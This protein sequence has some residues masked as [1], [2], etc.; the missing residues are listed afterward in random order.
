MSVTS[1]PEDLLPGGQ[2]RG[3]EAVQGGVVPSAQHRG[4]PDVNVS[5]PELCRRAVTLG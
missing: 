5:Y 3:R 4:L 1:D 2:G